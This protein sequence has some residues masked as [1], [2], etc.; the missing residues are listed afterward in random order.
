MEN[1]NK[2]PVTITVTG[3]E[4]VEGESEKQRNFA[5]EV[6]SLECTGFMLMLVTKGEDGEKHQQLV[7]HHVSGGDL[8]SAIDGHPQL[9]MAA[10]ATM[11][12]GL[13]GLDGL[14]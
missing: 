11:L 13:G 4:D 1:T 10:M 14:L 6:A 12:G 3:I 2:N 7:M 8:I 5:K 9:K